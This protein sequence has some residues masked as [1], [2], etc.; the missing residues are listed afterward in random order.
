MAC[1]S[2]VT[3]STGTSSQATY[4]L[5]HQWFCFARECVICVSQD[6]LV[7]LSDMDVTWCCDVVTAQLTVSFSRQ[8]AADQLIWYISWLLRSAGLHS[9]QVLINR[10]LLMYTNQWQDETSNTDFQCWHSL[11]TEI[12]TVLPQSWNT[13]RWL[14]EVAEWL[15]ES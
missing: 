1:N 13:W 11:F 12:M 15:T 10:R 9:E 8:T 14:M 3:G 7:W 4:Q 6:K 5:C 2:D